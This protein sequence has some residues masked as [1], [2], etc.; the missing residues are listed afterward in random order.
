MKIAK[1]VANMES[2]DQI[3]DEDSI[4]LNK[5][6]SDSLLNMQEQ[7]EEHSIRLRAWFC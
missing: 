6:I 5:E 1:V 3:N 4:L 7:Q 2:L